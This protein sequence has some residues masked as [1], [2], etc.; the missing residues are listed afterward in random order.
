MVRKNPYADNAV[1]TLVS[2]IIGNGIKPLINY[3]ENEK[4][5]AEIT[6]KFEEWIKE[7]DTSGANDF[8]GLQS[9]A[10]REMIEG[11][12]IFI[13]FRD[14]LPSDGL[15]VPLQLQLL[16]PEQ[17]DSSRT[18]DYGKK[19]IANGVEYDELGRVI[20]YHFRKEHPGD[21]FVRSADSVRVP[22]D[23]V[24]HLFKPLRAGQ[25][26]GLPWLSSVLVKLYELD[27]YDDA[28]LVRKKIAAM[29]TAFIT[30][31]DT[32]E[33]TSVLPNQT[34]DPDEPSVYSAALEPGTTQYLNPGESITFSQPADLGE[35]YKEFMRVQLQA[36]SVGLGLLY[37]Q[38]SGDLR[39][40][41]YSS[42][43]TGI[44]EFRKKVEAT[45][46][47][48]IVHQMCRPIYTEFVRK[49][50]LSGAVKPPRDFL[51]NEKSYY[52]CIWVTP[53]WE[54]VDP[55]KDVQ[56]TIKEI[57]SGLTSR[58]KVVASKGDNIVEL[59]KEIAKEQKREEELGLVFESNASNGKEEKGVSQETDAKIME[60]TDEKPTTPSK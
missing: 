17:L 55:L 27:Q 56:A 57:R 11:G 25:N 9:L 60:D 44:L 4:F 7:C 58:S 49:S 48:I 43:R 16:E 54:W 15:S 33:D 47:N 13:R 3:E 32:S 19:K 28:E 42:I 26:R 31:D 5:S 29:F 38:V 10:C 23:R 53:G 22:A 1:S 30:T 41:N 14:R 18:G 8:Y 50:I 36:V 35:N 21:L 12:E 45:Q 37:E 40:V 6:K 51:T 39:N 52:D 46:R 2:N 34:V 24:A 59:D 20:A